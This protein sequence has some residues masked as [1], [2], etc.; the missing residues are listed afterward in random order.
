LSESVYC[1]SNWKN[2]SQNILLCIF[3][4]F[5]S[6]HISHTIIWDSC[7]VQYHWN[8][9]FLYVSA[10][11]IFDL[12]H[13]VSFSFSITVAGITPNKIE[14]YYHLDFQPDEVHGNW[15]YL[16][17]S[18]IFMN[19]NINIGL[20]YFRLSPWCTWNLHSP[21]LLRGMSWLPMFQ[22][23]VPAQCAKVNTLKTIPWRCDTVSR[24][25]S[26][27]PTH[28][29]QRP[30]N[31]EDLSDFDT[32]NNIMWILFLWYL[33]FIVMHVSIMPHVPAVV[34]IVVEHSIVIYCYLMLH[35]WIPTLVWGRGEVTEHLS[36][37]FLLFLRH[38]SIIAD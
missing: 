23:C 19:Y 37:E 6:S 16:S 10:T 3:L 26:N 14:T 12:L 35:A 25:V 38:F 21:R 15:R 24:N 28:A 29:A 11:E 13:L 2:C 18:N 33:Q 4:N 5:L 32:N 30:Q 36:K 9:S 20:P 27:K 22:F 1:V 8:C 34:I 17:T 31:T 7:H